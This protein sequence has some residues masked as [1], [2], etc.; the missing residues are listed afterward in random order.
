MHLPSAPTQGT[1]PCISHALFAGEDPQAASR[2]VEMATPISRMLMACLLDS[3]SV[4]REVPRPPS[5]HPPA[6][7]ARDDLT[8]LLHCRGGVSGDLRPSIIFA[9]PMPA[10]YPSPAQGAFQGLMDELYRNHRD[11]FL[12]PRPHRATQE[13][14][15]NL[16][17]LLRLL[18]PGN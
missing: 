18:S 3:G 10:R 1:S 12:S 15:H 5:G 16:L 2:A 6:P 9:S 7:Q 11:D 14:V 4:P 13:Q 17:K 8:I